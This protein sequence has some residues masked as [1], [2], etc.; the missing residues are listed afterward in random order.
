MSKNLFLEEGGGT[1]QRSRSVSVIGRRCPDLASQADETVSDQV[2]V[3]VSVIIVSWNTRGLLEDCLRSVYEETRSIECEVIVVD[4]GSSDGSVEMVRRRF[5]QATLVANRI[6][7]GFAAANNQGMAA[8]VGRYFLLLNSDT[9]ILDRAIEKTVAFA[10]L[11]P[12]AA[13]TG[14][15]V[16]NPDRSL[17]PTCFMFPSLLNWLLL[18]SY[19][20][21]VFPR[22]RFFGREQ[23]TWWQRNDAREVDVV[24]GCF[25]LVRRDAIAQVGTMDERFFMYAEETDWCYRMS[26]AGWKRR[27]M[28]EAEIIHVGG[29][30]A[31]KWGARRARMT[32]ASFVRYVFKHW[33][34]P[35]A[36][37]GVCVIALFYAIR[38]IV[39]FPTCAFSSDVARRKRLDNHW[40]GL[41]DILAYRK[42][43]C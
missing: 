8:A 4:N 3:D 15:R 33:T 25:M 38:L 41:R 10:D 32:N 23:M 18:S 1:Q 7:R 22:N 42:H 26:R 2:S 28:P 34:R 11:H 39:L 30:S 12:D 14:C 13:V 5:P 16:L 27:F 43:L 31:A 29:A 24:T 20:P 19:L 21:R 9:K 36:V 17:Q 37:V 40:V 6:N 35:R